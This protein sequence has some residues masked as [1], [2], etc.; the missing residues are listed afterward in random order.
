[1]LPDDVLATLEAEVV[2]Q[3]DAGTHTLFLGRITAGEYFGN[4]E[5][6][7]YAYFRSKK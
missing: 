6:M 4:S 2:A 7:T 1:M 3:L 5:P